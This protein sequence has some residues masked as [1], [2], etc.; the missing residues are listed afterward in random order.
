[1][2][3]LEDG[4][5]EWGFAHPV[6]WAVLDDAAGKVRVRVK[7]RGEGGAQRT[8]SLSR[9]SGN[10]MLTLRALRRGRRQEDP[11]E[12]SALASTLRWLLWRLLRRPSSGSAPYRAQRAPWA[13]HAL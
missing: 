1:M 9:D 2:S 4:A 5:Y 12:V 8:G 11:R 6:V 10:L 13:S 7:E 3:V